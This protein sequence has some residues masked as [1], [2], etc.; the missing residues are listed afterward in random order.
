VFTPSLSSTVFCLTGYLC[1]A[2]LHSVGLNAMLQRLIPSRPP[3]TGDPEIGSMCMWSRLH[4]TVIPC[5]PLQRPGRLSSSLCS[6]SRSR[7]MSLS[8]RSSYVSTLQPRR[9]HLSTPL[10]L[11]VFE[12]LC[13]RVHPELCKHAMQLANMRCSLRTCDA[14][15]QHAM[16]L[17][18]AMALSCTSCCS[19]LLSLGNALRF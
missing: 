11:L 2:L 15:C 13:F 10:R 6:S 5:N 19:H 3:Q 12:R 14:A 1:T 18:Y 17:T 4:L 7:I 9:F 16:Q 8:H